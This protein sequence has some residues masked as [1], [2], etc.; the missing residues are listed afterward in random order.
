MSMYKID[1]FKVKATDFWATYALLD[2][3]KSH[4][5]RRNKFSF[6]GVWN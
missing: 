1:L 5:L 6:A 4:S 3:S 2:K